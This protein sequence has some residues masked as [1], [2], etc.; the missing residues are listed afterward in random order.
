V[1]TNP[2]SWMEASAYPIRI[3]ETGKNVLLMTMSVLGA[4]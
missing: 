2:Q 1:T 4:V 3:Y